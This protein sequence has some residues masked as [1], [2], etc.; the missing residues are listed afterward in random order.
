MNTFASKHSGIWLHCMNSIQQSHDNG[1]Y[2]DADKCVI[3]MELAV[4]AAMNNKYTLKEYIGK[5]DDIPDK[6]MMM[7]SW[8]KEKEI[9]ELPENADENISGTDLSSFSTVF[10]TLLPFPCAYV[11]LS[12]TSSEYDGFFYCI[13]HDRTA[14]DAG[15]E[16]RE[17]RF[18][19]ILIKKGKLDKA[20][21][22]PICEGVSIEEG[23]RM[24]FQMAINFDE[25]DEDEG[26]MEAL[27][28]KDKENQ[29]DAEIFP[30]FFKYLIY[31]GS[32]QSEMNI[33]DE[34]VMNTRFDRTSEDKE[35]IAQ[36]IARIWLFSS[37]STIP[38]TE[39]T[40]ENH[41]EDRTEDVAEAAPL[42]EELKI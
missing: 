7:Y 25:E 35:N 13:D 32:H 2:W 41:Q 12:A 22:F 27:S 9:L 37:V 15:D 31:L 8:K 26:W 3:P 23:I 33:K 21:I 38:Q 6:V 19:I 42:P 1:Y 11:D 34:T 29:R 17:Y 18:N 4:D 14:L 16:E 40:D 39:N 10:L 24:A 30:L 36:P 28:E 5:D 20:G